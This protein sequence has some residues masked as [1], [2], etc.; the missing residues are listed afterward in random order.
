MTK[1]DINNI[2][3]ISY[4]LDLGHIP[5]ALSWFDF[6]DCLLQMIDVNQYKIV[7]G[8]FWGAQALYYATQKNLGL[9]VTETKNI[10]F[11]ENKNFETIGD[12]L[13]Y[14]SGIAFAQSKPVIFICSDAVFQS[15]YMYEAINFIKQYHLNVL[16]LVDNNNQ[17]VC[18]NIDDIQ[19][20]QPIKELLKSCF[21]Y[22]ECNGHNRDEIK[23]NLKLML[24]LGGPKVMFFRTVKGYGIQE[25]QAP[26][27]HYRKLSHEDLKRFTF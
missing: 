27:W 26:D 10:P 5:S 15:G 2:L 16:I 8:K 1:T 17:Q 18:G 3:K 9:T 24:S 20:I 21:L 11:L 4:D 14:A 7:L 12:T 22:C 25:M 6:L 23:K 13:G 19:S